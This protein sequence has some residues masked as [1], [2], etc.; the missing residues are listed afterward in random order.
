MKGC[1]ESYLKVGAKPHQPFY[2]S[3]SSI[4][5]SN[6]IQ[7]KYQPSIWNAFWSQFELAFT[8]RI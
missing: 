1:V 8:F 7:T 5:N 6:N 3:G 4:N 2:S